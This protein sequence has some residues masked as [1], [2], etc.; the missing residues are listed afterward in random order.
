[1]TDTTV[2][3]LFNHVAP[4]SPAKGTYGI[5]ANTLLLRGQITTLDAAGRAA[6]PGAGQD[7]IGVSFATYRNRTTDDSGGAADAMN[8]EVKHGL[9]NFLISGTTPRPR[10]VVYVVDNQT[11][12]VDATGNRGIAGVVTEVRTE[13][14][15]AQAYVLMGPHVLAF[16][17]GPID[18]DLPLGSFRLASGAALPAFSAGVD[19]FALV[20]SEAFGIRIND[21]T[22]TVMWTSCKLPE[23]VPAGATIKLHALVSRIGATDTAAELF[24]STVFAN[25][26]GALYD[27]GASLV[28]G[29]YA[30]IADATTTVVERTLTITGALGGDA[31]SIS[32]AGITANLANDDLLVSAM[33]ISVR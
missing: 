14:G 28:T 12:S 27:A 8:A 21:D 33:W 4:L 11:V 23:H 24:T 15:V 3:R 17:R 31:L 16:I 20:A 19:G 5:A 9:F 13:N 26:K 29:N 30:L 6:V 22:T 2:E 25:R 7:A 18:I 1:M 10:Q 32:L